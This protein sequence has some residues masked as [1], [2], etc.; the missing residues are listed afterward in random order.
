VVGVDFSPGG[1]ALLQTLEALRAL[2][3]KRLILVHSGA[4]PDPVD[5]GWLPSAE[6]EIFTKHEVRLNLERARLAASGFEVEVRLDFQYP[7]DAIVNTAVERE[8]SLI[9]VGSRSHNRMM[10]AF[11]G[12][13][14]WDVVRR[15]PVPVLIERITP[16]GSTSERMAVSGGGAFERV[17]FPTDWSR[18]AGRAFDEV[19][20]I[21]TTGAIRSFGIIRVRD[22]IAEA[23]TGMTTEDDDARLLEA[24]AARLRAAGADEVWTANPSGSPF[25]EILAAAGDDGR[26][27]IVMGT[28]GRGMISDAFLGSV[29]RDVVRH[30]KGAILLVPRGSREEQGGA[31]ES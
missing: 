10:D 18:T 11:V 29:S 22:Q 4:V 6:S 5:E 15:A 3:A 7:G 8:A 1:E 27:L 31:G 21:A 12:S 25:K 13:V 20:R 16:T 30:G 26:T 14:A 19:I 9:V 23:R 17:L 28:Q 24:A 2:G